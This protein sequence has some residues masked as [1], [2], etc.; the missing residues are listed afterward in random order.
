MTHK[1]YNYRLI[2]WRLILI[3]FIS[4]Y[5][6]LPLTGIAGWGWPQQDWNL[7][8]WICKLKPK[9]LQSQ[10]NRNNR[11]ILVFCVFWGVKFAVFG[12]RVQWRGPSGQVYWF[13]PKLS[14]RVCLDFLW[15]GQ[16]GPAPLVI[17][18]KKEKKHKRLPYWICLACFLFGYLIC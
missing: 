12:T 6:R 18:S 8:P 2:S 7:F 4:L 10:N 15:F 16:R 1:D 14:Q 5:L 9:E 3:F 11:K 17:K 13:L